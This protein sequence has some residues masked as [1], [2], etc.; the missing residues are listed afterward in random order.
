M[1]SLALLQRPIPSLV[2]NAHVYSFLREKVDLGV[3]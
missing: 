3:E 2:Q 1:K